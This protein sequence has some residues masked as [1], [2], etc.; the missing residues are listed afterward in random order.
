[1]RH[2]CHE[3]GASFIEKA[4]SIL[5][6]TSVQCFRN[7]P[8][9]GKLGYDSVIE[10]VTDAVGQKLAKVKNGITFFCFRYICL[11]YFI[12]ICC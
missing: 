1:M 6:G 2:S 8:L 12:A 4:S 10:P 9:C 3:N 7:K 11:C 5:A